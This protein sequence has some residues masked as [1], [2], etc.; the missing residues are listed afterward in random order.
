MVFSVSRLP[1][2]LFLAAIVS[3][4]SPLAVAACTVTTLPADWPAASA[5]WD[6]ECAGNVADGLG[7][8]KEV[9]G[10]QVMRLVFGRAAH[11][12]LQQGVL[13]LPEG[14]FMAGRFDHGQVVASDDR[15]T[16]IDAFNVAADAAGAVAA[17]YESAG[18]GGSA[19]F[20]RLK[21]RTLRNQL[22]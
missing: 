18:N 15:Q 16:L 7:V 14:G 2:R 3:L 17:R 20:Y 12:E 19:Q 22:D 10:A 9:R 5:R 11:G 13:D 1:S 4:L 8:L 6:G 21:E